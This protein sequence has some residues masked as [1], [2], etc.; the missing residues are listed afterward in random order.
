MM[1]L[2]AFL[3]TPNH[4]YCVGV[5]KPA[6]TTIRE[7]SLG[8]N[9]IKREK[10]SEG[11]LTPIYH[12]RGVG[13]SELVGEASLLSKKLVNSAVDFVRLVPGDPVG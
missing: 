11:K 9:E 3:A 1:P 12:H 5:S 10:A 2:S 7:S 13:G 4:Y 6:K 8:I